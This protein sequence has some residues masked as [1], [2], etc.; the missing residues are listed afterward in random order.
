MHDPNDPTLNMTIEE[1]RDQIDQFEK[2]LELVDDTLALPD[3]DETS[4]PECGSLDVTET[5]KPDENG[6]CEYMCL[7]CGHYFVD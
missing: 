2:A 5:T 7:D 6:L 1:L 4:C 3:Y